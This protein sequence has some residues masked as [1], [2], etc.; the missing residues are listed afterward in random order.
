LT[1]RTAIFAL[2]LAAVPRPPASAAVGLTQ[3]KALSTA[4]PAG[5]IVDRQTSFLTDAQLAKARELAGPG[6][7][8]ASA[9]VTRYVGRDPAGRVVGTAYFDTHRVRTLQE[10]LMIVAGPDG[11]AL[12]VDVLAFGEPPD[13]LPKK[14]W[15]DQFVGRGLD[16]ELSVK[17]GIH[18]IT[19][20]TLSSQAATDAVR[21]ILAIH[22]V[23][24]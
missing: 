1:G 9:L 7:E 4:F 13:Y 19:G 5:S 12:R 17:R 14:G 20:A 15:L 24:P 21:R 3:D 23:L 6:I 10:T 18:G 11:K 22:A 8:L 2:V 16:D